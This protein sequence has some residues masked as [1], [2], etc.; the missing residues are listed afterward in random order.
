MKNGFL[1]IQDVAEVLF[2]KRRGYDRICL[3]RQEIMV[4]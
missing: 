3:T 1:P 4:Y 2:T